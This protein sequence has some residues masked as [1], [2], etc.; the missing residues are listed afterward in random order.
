M[1][2][3]LSSGKL[4]AQEDHTSTNERTGRRDSTANSEHTTSVVGSFDETQHDK[5]A[6]DSIN[7][8]GTPLPDFPS[9]AP[10]APPVPEELSDEEEDALAENSA[11]I[12]QIDK[13][14]LQAEESQEFDWLFEYGLEMD[15]TIL[16]SPE[17]LDGAALLYGPAVLKGYRILFGSVEQ[18]GG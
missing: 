18:P 2:A 7:F 4:S 17:R 10:S 11:P 3:A 12:S 6:L 16:N 5:T 14:S 8:D 9:K 15:S 1:L 13:A